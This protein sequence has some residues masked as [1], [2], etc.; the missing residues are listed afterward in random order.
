LRA[1]LEIEE[2]HTAAF[3]LVEASLADGRWDTKSLLAAAYRAWR[4]WSQNRAY[5]GPFAAQVIRSALVLKALSYRPTGAIVAAPTT[6]LPEEIGGMRNWDYRFC[7]VRDACLCFY[8]LKKFG[9]TTEAEQFLAFLVD[10][11]ERGP[12]GKLKPLYAIDGSV[13]STER[14]IAH[15]EGYR[16]S[17]PVRAANEA[18]GQHQLDVYGQILD[19]IYLYKRLGGELDARLE[20]MGVVLADYVASHWREPDNGLWEPR[21]EAKRYV[22][23][24]IMNWV[25]L[26]RALRLFGPREKWSREREA[27]AAE[28][29]SEGVH[30]EGFLTQVFGGDDVDAALLIAPMVDFP[31]SENVLSKT[32]DKIIEQLGH[33]SLVHRYKSPDGLPGEEGTFLICAFWMVDALAFLGRIDEAKA[34]FL[35]LLGL[36]NDVGLYPE[37][38]GHD[39]EFLGNFPQAFSHLGF[40]HSAL[41]LELYAAG[42]RE[43]VRGTYAD[44]TQRETPN[45]R[46]TRIEGTEG[47]SK[48][49]Q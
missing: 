22:H 7:W 11:F 13:D 26:D 37:E 44:R 41:V 39:G 12:E 16:G 38:I 36:A 24:A 31:I 25:A 3:L 33:G 27:I 21:C 34:R 20:E 49:A 1:R 18:A 15:Y 48:P 6:S 30:R 17:A 40:I 47:G 46:P 10:I 45:R 19:L 5:D 9:S 23:G 2:G 8:A 35:D 28:V 32:V 43:A 42:G 4:G 29:N 14:V